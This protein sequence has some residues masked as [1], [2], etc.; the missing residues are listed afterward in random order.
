MGMAKVCPSKEALEVT[1]KGGEKINPSIVGIS[2]IAIFFVFILIEQL[3][4]KWN[5]SISNDELRILLSGSEYI[6]HP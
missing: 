6:S 2:V 1:L 5:S 3:N 4:G